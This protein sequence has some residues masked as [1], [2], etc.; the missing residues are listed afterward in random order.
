MGVLAATSLRHFRQTAGVASRWGVGVRH[1]RLPHHYRAAF[2][3]ARRA[4]LAASVDKQG[5]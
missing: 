5:G 4:V 3:I 1:A 2:P